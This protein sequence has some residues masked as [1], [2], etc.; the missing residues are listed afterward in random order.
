MSAVCVSHPR[1]VEHDF[2]RHPEHAGRIR[3]VWEAL[4]ESGL[5]QMLLPALP[6]PATDAQ[7]LSVHSEAHLRRLVNISRGHGLT[8]IDQDTYALPQSLEVARLAA[9]AAV[10]AVDAVLTGESESAMALVRPPG[11]HATRGRQMGFCLLNNIAIGARH[12][13]ERH[14]LGRVLIF[15]YDVHHGNGTQD[16]FYADPNVMFISIHQSP[17]YPGTGSLAEIGS[18]AGRGST[19]NLPIP[20][21]YGDAGYQALF[22]EVVKP[23]VE[24]YQPELMLISLGFD[25]YF[26][27]P[28]SG[29]RLSL[30]GYDWLARATIELAGQV[31]N[32]KIVFVMEGGYD[33]AALAHGWANVARALLDIHEVSDPFGAP[34]SARS[35][36]SLNQ[37][38]AE[39]QRLHR[40]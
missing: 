18:G 12:A 19:M 3:A 14:Q 2:P 35:A 34:R 32:G 38:I 1:F 5:S 16:I 6:E 26:S 23:A 7:I 9:G 22:R 15:D 28:L 25:A 11:H 27:D 4:D 40:L 29:M 13:V 36:A 30:G 21:G 24:R 10:R 37:I 39:T 8:L 17:H 20:A 33:L 31:C